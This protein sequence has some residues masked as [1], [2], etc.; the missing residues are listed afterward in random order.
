MNKTKLTGNLLQLLITLLLFG[1][2]VLAEE[3]PNILVLMA[4]DMSSRVRS[5]GDSVAVTPNLDRL[6]AEG[7]RYTNVFATAGV[8]A[9]SRAAFIT[10]MHQVSIGAQHMRA[11]TRPEGA[12]KSVPPAFVKAFPEYLRQAGYFTFTDMKLDY[13]FSGVFSET[14]PFT[15][16][17]EEGRDSDWS[18]RSD[19]QP[20][21]GLINFAVTHESGVF[22]PLG[23]WPNNW[24][25]FFSQVFRFVSGPT[26]D[27]EVVEPGDIVLEPYYADTETARTD[28]ARHYNNIHV[29][30]LQVGKLIDRLELEGLLDETI[31]IW[32]TDHGDGLPRAKRE[33]YD[34]G[35]KVPMIIRWPDLRGQG[36]LESRLVSFID[37]APTIMV[38]AGVPVPVHMQ[39]NDFINDEPRSYIYASRDRIDTF[40]DRRRA[41]RDHRYKYIRSWYPEK[42]TGHLL[43]YRDNI[44]MVQEMREKYEAG[45]LNEAQ[46]LWYLPTGEEQLFDLLLDPY[47]LQNL[48]NDLEF[49]GVRQ[50]LA[51]QLASH[52]EEIG[53]M[54][55]LSE[56]DMVARMHPAGD[57]AVTATPVLDL[58]DGLITV[59]TPG[60][61]IGYS[62]N[63]GPWHNYT[64]RVTLLPGDRVAVKAVRYGWRESEVGDY[65]VR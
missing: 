50:R 49:A 35:I 11:S 25:H 24:G 54:S 28:I 42:A 1:V 9:P 37:L 33:L 27:V 56:Q 20:F 16:W 17:N 13:Q 58:A 31:I 8:C 48:S 47:E 63:G 36:A 59:D 64:G 34:S 52:F 18:A 43:S 65:L 51:D 2:P 26:A 14:G 29:M 30:D 44:P 39:G 21:F 22:P 41:V 40:V 55:E 23:Y 38:L 62:V 3:R 10:G 53:D 5:F 45:E 57:S 32:T 6:A 7:V 4:E 19:G 61:S 46:R 12:Y 60:A 15:I